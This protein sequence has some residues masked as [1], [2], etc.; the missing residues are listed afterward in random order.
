MLSLDRNIIRVFPRRTS[1]TPDDELAFVGEPPLV[2][3]EADEVHVSVAFTWDKSEGERLAE[4]WAAFYPIVKLGG[5][6]FNSP[7]EDF[8]PGMYLKSGVTIT[9]RGCD[10]N[11]W[12]CY[13]PKREGMIC[14]LPITDGHII[15]D[16]NLLA[17]STEHI[18]AVLK[19]CDRQKRT[20]RFLGGLD[21]FR[22]DK[23]MAARFCSLSRF[24]ELWFAY[25][26]SRQFEALR[27]AIHQIAYYPRDI[28]CYVLIG[29]PGDTVQKARI[30]LEATAKAGAM[31]FAM[32]YH[33][34]TGRPAS[35]E[36]RRLQRLWARPALMRKRCGGPLFRTELAFAGVV[37]RPY[38][39]PPGRHDS[40]PQLQ[41]TEAP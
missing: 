25:D 24:P 28:R 27:K 23:A 41:L 1:M 2:R 38:E 19:M 5:P 7:A 13:V 31:P 26:T 29:Y 22:F 40:Q 12:F 10:S 21:V 6:A 35:G 8:V 32:L 9:S 30:R 34:D 36:W 3:P 4:A 15:Q 37:P 11:C 18:E 20:V 16:N 17:C 14:T 39:N 33:D